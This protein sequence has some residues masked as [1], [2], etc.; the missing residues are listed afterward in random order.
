M[1]L[2]VPA[3]FAALYL[4]LHSFMV[5]ACAGG[6]ERGGSEQAWLSQTV[7]VTCKHGSAPNSWVTAMK[8]VQL[9][10]ASDMHFL[11]KLVCAAPCRFCAAA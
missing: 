3:V 4:A 10:V 9:P 6:L 7:D 2:R 8:F 11:V 1:P 5:S